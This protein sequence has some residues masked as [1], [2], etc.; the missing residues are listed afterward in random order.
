MKRLNLMIFPAM[1]CGIFLTLTG[2]DKNTMEEVPDYYAGK[3]KI[4]SVNFASNYA[5]PSTPPVWDFSEGDMMYLFDEDGYMYVSGEMAE[6]DLDS[7]TDRNYWDLYLNYGI[8]T[9]AYQYAATSPSPWDNGWIQ[10][11]LKIGDKDYNLVVSD[12]KSQMT[13]TTKVLF[14][15]EIPW[16]NIRTTSSDAVSQSARFEVDVPQSFWFEVHL[17]KVEEN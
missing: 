1:I 7:E 14:Y 9:G 12:D 4:T 16:L 11:D 17:E 2:C 15:Y 8:E 10:W 5:L 3:W 13:V 6:P